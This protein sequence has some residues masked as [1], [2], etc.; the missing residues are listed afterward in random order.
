MIL[1]VEPAP[2]TIET[3]P[4]EPWKSEVVRRVLRLLKFNTASGPFRRVRGRRLSYDHPN[5]NLWVEEARVRRDD[6]LAVIDRLDPF[7]AAN[8][9]AQLAAQAQ[10][11]VSAFGPKSDHG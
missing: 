2:A 5:F 8:V 4:S 3:L 7:Q 10:Q 6:F 11:R 9:Q 1:L